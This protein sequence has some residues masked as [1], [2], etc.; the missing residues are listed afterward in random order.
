MQF[1]QKLIYFTA[2]LLPL[3]G[4]VQAAAVPGEFEPIN[5]AQ[6]LQR[7]IAADPWLDLNLVE[8]EVAEGQIE[9][10]GLRP[11]P[12]LGS[13][14]ENVLGS[15]GFRGADRA[16]FTL[17][18]TQPIETAGK[19]HK[20]VELARSERSLLDWERE[21]RL[22]DL[23][24][25]VR[26]AYIDVLAAQECLELRQ[27]QLALAKRSRDETARLVDAARVSQVE[28]TRAELAVQ[29]QQFAVEQAVRDLTRA[30][31]SLAVYWGEAAG[32]GFVVSGALPL[33]REPPELE[34][35]INRLP[36]SIHLAPFELR[37]RS[38]A[39]ALKL[40]EAIA[41]PDIDLF[42]GGRYFNEASG[43][44]AFVVGVEIPWAL[45][46]RN[47]GNVRSARA[48]VHALTY[49]KAA[50]RR[51]IVRALTDA[52]QRLIAANEAV[53]N[54]E[55]RLLPVAKQTLDETEA[56]YGRGQFTL[57]S[58]L[59]SRQTLFEIREAH[60]Q[61]LKNYALAHAEIEALTRPATIPTKQ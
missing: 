7:A 24:A 51:E 13:E 44:T 38:R 55:D 5:Y 39:A 29:R 12:V 37:E 27:E 11:N 17:S 21:R 30:C 48:R 52:Y 4:A 6:A 31:A 23:E 42:G 40:E 49:E 22:A 8:I 57:L 41:K 50:A 3:Y 16:E 19:R 54:I 32:P 34:Q 59:E 45:F 61:T 26:V 56:G 9:Q 43:E 18:L 2:T 46:D 28:S 60:L 1:F 10:A 33:D 14:V 20:R 25:A 35:L 53:Q 47:Q 36:A 15:G 58:V